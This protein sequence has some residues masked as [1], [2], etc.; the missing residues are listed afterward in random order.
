MDIEREKQKYKSRKK[1]GKVGEKLW[2]NVK[3]MVTTVWNS[4]KFPA[5]TQEK[6]KPLLS[7]K[8]R[9][10]LLNVDVKQLINKIERT[11]WMRSQTIHNN[12]IGK[13]ENLNLHRSFRL[14]TFSLLEIIFQKN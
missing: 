1:G 12:F 11:A 10:I 8:R 5:L 6:L 4:F 7:Y 13:K 3:L 14:L 2:K 9:K